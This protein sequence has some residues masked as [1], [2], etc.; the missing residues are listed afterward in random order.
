[1]ATSGSTGIKKKEEPDRIAVSEKVRAS[2]ELYQSE[3]GILS[4]AEDFL[5]KK[6]LKKE[7]IAAS[8]R[9]LTKQYKALLRQVSKITSLGDGTQSKLRRTQEELRN[10]LTELEKAQATLRAEL[11][12][13]RQIQR[14]LLP[15]VPPQVPGVEIHSEYI[16]L[17]E[18]GGDFI[19]YTILDGGGLGILIGDATGHGVPAALMASMAKIA[20]DSLRGVALKPKELLSG[21]NTAL[22]GKT[23]NH[24]V[25]ACYAA[26]DPRSRSLKLAIGGHPPPIVLPRNG[27]PYAIEGR[28]QMLGFF[29]DVRIGEAEKFLE[30]G[31]R[32]LFL[33][34]GVLECMAEDGTEI[35]DAT[36]LSMLAEVMDR[37][38]ADLIH[39]FT[40]RLKAFV[41][42]RGFIDDVTLVLVA[43][44]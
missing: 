10:A 38:P 37:S 7:D 36:V 43:P 34:D 1:M 42:S 29:P 32:L 39:L 27:K 15:I 18:V 19:D 9:E 25:T 20:L 23:S 24:F 35:D 21:L 5:K 26:Y 4:A 6:K 12:L 40:E 13:A 30:P 3:Y 17:E 31:D 44:A 11:S 16:S 2:D 22:V 33:T 14:Q 28:G 8:Y 41:G